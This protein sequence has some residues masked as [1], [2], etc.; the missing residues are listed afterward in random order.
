M[1]FTQRRASGTSDDRFSEGILDFT[2]FGEIVRLRWSD[3]MH[4]NQSM[5]KLQS[6]FVLDFGYAC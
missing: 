2:L 3:T 5:I 4:D 6:I 1:V